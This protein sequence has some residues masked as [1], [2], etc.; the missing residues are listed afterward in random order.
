MAFETFDLGRT[1]QQAEQIKALRLNNAL[2][3]QQQDPNSP[4]NQVLRQNLQT[5]QERLIGIQQD[6]ALK[7]YEVDDAKKEQDLYFAYD[8]FTRLKQN[9]LEHSNISQMFQDRGMPPLQPGPLAPEVIQANADKAIAI[10][11]QQL[12]I[13]NQRKQA[14]KN[15]GGDVNKNIEETKWYFGLSPEQQ[16][17]HLNVKRAARYLDTGAEFVTPDPTNPTQTTP[18]VKKEVAKEK[19][20]EYKAAVEKATSTASLSSTMEKELIEAN[21]KAEVSRNVIGMLEEAS[22]LNKAAYSGYGAMSRATAR[23]NL[24]GASA[25]ADATVN[26]DNIMTG[27]ALESLKAIFGGM[28]TE[29]ERKI[30][31][32]MQASV[33]KTPQ[34]RADII[35]RASGLAKKRIDY[36]EKKVESIKNGT[37][38]A[39][40]ANS[41]QQ[42]S[43]AKYR[44]GDVITSPSGRKAIVEAVGQDGKPS[45]L[46]LL[47]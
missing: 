31:L 36:N 45:K 42:T 8:Q 39:V 43:Q 47:K 28:P 35:A 40:G 41:P 6:N 3:Q 5:G 16:K 18:V 37:Y 9:P 34:Q 21:D 46:K 11:K 17:A 44:V 4:Q 2:A 15:S 32:E 7:G 30:L 38:S 33:G 29:G 27:Q 12:D 14:R 25:G 20:P 10:T 19:T 24:P 1:L 13:L 23:S 26:L 22:A